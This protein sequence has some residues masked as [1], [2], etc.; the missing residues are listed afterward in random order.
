MSLLN[1]PFP[2]KFLALSKRTVVANIPPTYPQLSP[3]SAS[4][5]S[6][7]IPYSSRLVQLGSD[8]LARDKYYDLRYRVPYST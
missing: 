4:V 7:R 6:D 8:G 5:G 1:F 3:R 2:S